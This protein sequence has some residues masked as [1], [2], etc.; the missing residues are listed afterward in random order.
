M[1]P[2]GSPY[3]DY[4]KKNPRHRNSKGS[5]PF[6]VEEVGFPIPESLF[7]GKFAPNFTL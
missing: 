3:F 6:T 2:H 7:Y 5:Q 1:Y 4:R